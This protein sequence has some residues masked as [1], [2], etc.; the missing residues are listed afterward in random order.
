MAENFANSRWGGGSPTLPLL[1]IPSDTHLPNG[2]SENLINGALDK[3]EYIYEESKQEIWWIKTVSISG[4]FCVCV[5]AKT[6][7]VFLT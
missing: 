1:Y 6:N 4:S 5:C 7:I 3:Y 2:V